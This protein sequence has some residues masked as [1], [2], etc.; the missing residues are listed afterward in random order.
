M[1]P[2]WALHAGGHVVAVTG[3]VIDD[4]PAPG[5]AVTGVTPRSTAPDVPQ[6]VVADV[7]LWDGCPPLVWPAPSGSTRAR[8]VRASRG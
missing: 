3:D 6:E 8:R 4:A 7:R 2:G 1:E 5:T